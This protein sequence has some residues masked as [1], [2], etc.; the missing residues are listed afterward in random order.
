MREDLARYQAPSPAPTAKG[1]RLRREARNVF[2]VDG[3][4]GADAR[5]GADLPRRHCHAA[6]CLHYFESLTLEGAKAREIADKVV[7]EIRSRLQ[8]PQRR[9]PQLPEP[10]PQRRH[11]LRRRGAAH[12]PASQIGSGL[13]GVMYVLDEPSIGLHQRDN[14]RLIG[15]LRHL[16]DLGNSVLVVEHDEDAIRAADHVID[17]GPG[18]GVH[19][20]AWRRARRPRRWRPNPDSLTGRYLARARSIAVPKRRHTLAQSTDPQLLKIVARAATT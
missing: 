14:E 13:T 20:G 6:R 5:K 12:P 8:V 15:T 1:T 7:R 16:R 17:I 10:G 19:G 2:L 3:R 18:A 11:A 9:R 4:A